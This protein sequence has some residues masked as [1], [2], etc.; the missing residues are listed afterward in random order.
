D[1]VVIVATALQVPDLVVGHVGN[2]FLG[3]RT[4]AEE[5]LANERA[6]LVLVGLVVA[7]RGLVHDVNQ[8]AGLVGFEQGIPLAAPSNLDDIPA[9]TA[10]EGF[11]FL[12]DLA[13]AAN[14]AVKA[15]QVAVDD[16]VQVIELLVGSK[17]QEAARLWLVHFAVTQEGPDLL[18]GGVLDAAVLQVAVQLCLV[19]GVSWA[20]A[21]RHGR[22]FPEVRKR[23]WVRVGRKRMAFLRLFLAES[24]HVLFGQAAFEER[25]GVHA[26]GRL[27]LEEDLVATAWVVL[28]AEEMVETYFIQGRCTGV[29]GD[30]S[31]NT[32][33]GVLSA[34]HHDGCIPAHEGAVAAL[35]GFIA[36]EFWFLVNRNG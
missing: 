5:V 4:L 3:F 29:G 25:A 15:L 23:A 36:R 32:D 17:L 21:H 30:V 12:H 19:D 24:V 6:G 14:R 7:I 28:A 22:E 13:I 2:Q 11:Q 34:V 27:A 9:G 35:D 20:D 33:G 10:E 1:L 26:R 8:G 18:V 16:E 31:A